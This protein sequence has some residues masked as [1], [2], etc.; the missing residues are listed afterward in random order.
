MWSG[1]HEMFRGNW[2]PRSRQDWLLIMAPL[3]LKLNTLC[4]PSLLLN[5]GLYGLLV[6]NSPLRGNSSFAVV[7]S[8]PKA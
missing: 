7:A 2:N 1:V 8:T 4:G 3:T 6:T 5:V